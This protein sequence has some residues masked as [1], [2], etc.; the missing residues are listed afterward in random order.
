L[1]A[2]WGEL[3]SLAGDGGP[4]PFTY[5]MIYSPR[6]KEEIAVVEQILKAA[7]QYH[8]ANLLERS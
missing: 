1:E 8:A 5:L 3:H 6:K 4:L 2:G 7:V